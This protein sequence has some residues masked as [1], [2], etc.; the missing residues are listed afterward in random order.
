M[1]NKYIRKAK[2][3]DRRYNNTGPGQVGPIETRLSTFPQTTGLVFGAYGEASESVECLLRMCAKRIAAL[4]WRSLGSRSAKEAAG[5][6][7]GTMRARVGV[8]GV[9][10]HAQLKARR[11]LEVLGNSVAGAKVAAVRR[12]AARSWD[13]RCREDYHLEA[14]PSF[15]APGRS[16]GFTE[17]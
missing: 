2:L 17:K 11:R 14:R 6:V 5:F 1:E 12:A 10:T 13:R 8:L 4:K 15:G 9:R 3:A 7:L 16:D